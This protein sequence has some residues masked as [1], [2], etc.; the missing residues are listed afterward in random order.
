M[1]I[2][3]RQ[4]RPNTR[5]QPLTHGITTHLKTQTQMGI[6]PNLPH[7]QTFPPHRTTETQAAIKLTCIGLH[8]QT[9]AALWV[10]TG[11]GDSTHTTTALV[12]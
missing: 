5:V 2:I 4:T 10:T 8:N 3:H 1:D 6:M 11:V 12:P 9:M 7:N